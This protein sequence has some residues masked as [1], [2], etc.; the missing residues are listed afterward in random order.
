MD[1]G[2]RETSI[3]EDSFVIENGSID[4]VQRVIGGFNVYNA[5]VRPNDIDS[6]SQ[7]S[8]QLKAEI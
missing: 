1:E 6:D 2:I 3:T 4:S 5:I 8:I 7:I